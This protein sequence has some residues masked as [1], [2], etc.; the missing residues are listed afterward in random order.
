MQKFAISGF[1][2]A[3]TWFAEASHNLTW[4][5]PKRLPK[6][7]N[8]SFVIMAAKY[9]IHHSAFRHSPGNFWIMIDRDLPTA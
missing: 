3:D 4:I 5:R 2:D 9:C 7:M 1:I 6:L 8:V